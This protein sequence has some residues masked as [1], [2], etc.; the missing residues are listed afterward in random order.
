MALTQPCRKQPSHRGWSMSTRQNLLRFNGKA[1]GQK[2]SG[3]QGEKEEEITGTSLLSSFA[4]FPASSFLMEYE[5][6]DTPSL[7]NQHS[8]WLEWHH[9]SAQGLHPRPVWSAAMVCVG[10]WEDNV[11]EGKPFPARHPWVSLSSM[12]L[13]LSQGLDSVTLRRAFSASEAVRIPE[14]ITG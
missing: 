13:H 4:S 11:G 1:L 12:S 5:M 7:V 10:M 6:G 14:I 8:I 9:F 3:K 2:E